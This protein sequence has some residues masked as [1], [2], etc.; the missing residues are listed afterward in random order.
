[1][2]QLVVCLL[3]GWAAWAGWSRLHAGSAE[4]L[5]AEPYVVV[6]GRDR[7]GLTQHMR[8]ELD[9][10]G[11]PYDYQQI[12]DPAVADPLHERMESAGISTRSYRLPVVDVSGHLFVSPDA[13]A[14]V[15]EL[16]AGAP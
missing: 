12:D 3:L 14:V 4:P 16:A 8:S 7:C 9:R 2:K 13:S 15:G 1:V 6:Y 10:E 11:V 5:S